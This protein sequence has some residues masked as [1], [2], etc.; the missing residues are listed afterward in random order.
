MMKVSF[1]Q[2][3]DG[4]QAEYQLLDR[5][6]RHQQVQRERAHGSQTGLAMQDQP[7]AT[8]DGERGA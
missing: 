8:T 6:E 4:T 7:A 5:L 3:K 1:R 2:M